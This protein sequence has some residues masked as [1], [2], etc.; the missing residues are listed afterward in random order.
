[1]LLASFFMYRTGEKKSSKRNFTFT[2]SVPLQFLTPALSLS[3]SL[4]RNGFTVWLRWR[5]LRVT[6]KKNLGNRRSFKN[7]RCCIAS[8]HR[9]LT[10]Y[11]H[12]HTYLPRACSAW[13]GHCSRL[14]M[15][16]IG[17]FF[18][19]ILCGFPSFFLLCTSVFVV[20]FFVSGAFDSSQKVPPQNISII[21]LPFWRLWSRT[22]WPRFPPLPPSPF[23]LFQISRNRSG[24]CSFPWWSHLPCRTWHFSPPEYRSKPGGENEVFFS[25]KTTTAMFAIRKRRIYWLGKEK[26]DRLNPP[27]FPPLPS[28]QNISLWIFWRKRKLQIITH[29]IKPN[30]FA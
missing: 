21:V 5:R 18:I 1:M 15:R 26:R 16:E 20:V 4:S 3:L 9:V 27:P 17:F 6:N 14:V 23:F 24:S 13:N 2:L 8:H 10:F 28:N 7:C 19:I 30:A 29:A 25:L 22:L 11:H 12:H